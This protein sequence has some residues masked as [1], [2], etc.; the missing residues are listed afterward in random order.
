MN[1]RGKLQATR[2]SI[3]IV[4]ARDE[5][6]VV[7]TTGMAGVGGAP[8]YV[9]YGEDWFADGNVIVGE[10]NEVYPLRVLGSA[11]MEGTNAIYK[12]ELMGGVVTGMPVEELTLGKRFSIEY[13]P[14]ERE[15]SRGVGDV[16]YTSPVAMRNEWSH[17]RIKHK[18]P[19]SMLGKKL[20]VGI[21][22]WIMQV[23]KLFTI[24]GCTMLI[25]TQKLLSLMR[26]ITLL[27]TV[28]VTVT[29]ME[30]I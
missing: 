30:N 15:L 19:G 17:I 14:V 1:T 26:R 13:S 7:L 10:K 25:G 16:R 29:V 11:R 12:V 9:V 20:A 3:P 8:F 28:V 5:D 23:R 27:C 24:C 2:R 18:V 21:P 22:L 4:E 6:G